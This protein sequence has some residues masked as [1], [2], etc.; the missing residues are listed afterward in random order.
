[1]QAAGQVTAGMGEG[2]EGACLPEAVNGPQ[3]PREQ[4]PAGARVG[5]GVWGRGRPSGQGRKSLW[6]QDLPP[7]VRVWE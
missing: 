1:M 7:G 5:S 3:A 4:V 2:Q 6:G